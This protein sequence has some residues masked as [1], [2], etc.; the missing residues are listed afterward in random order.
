MGRS[1]LQGNSPTYLSPPLRQL[2]PPSS[3]HEDWDTETAMSTSRP[4]SLA[5]ARTASPGVKLPTLADILSNTAP[6]PWT[7]SAFTAYLSQNHCLETLEFIMEAERYRF[8]HLHQPATQQR[9]LHFEDETICSLWQRL[10]QAYIM[11]YGPREVNLP[12]PVRDRLLKLDYSL[13]AVPPPSELDEAVDIVRELMSDSLLVPFLESFTHAVFETRIEEEVHEERKSRSRLRIPKDLISSREEGSQSPKTNFLPLLGLGRSS[14]AANRSTLGCEPMELDLVTDDSSSP[15]STPGDEPMTPPTTPPTSD[16]T[17]ST[18]PNSLQRAIS[19]NSW[20]K[21]GAKLGLSRKN[22]SMRR[23]HPTKTSQSRPPTRK[24][25]QNFSRA[26]WEDPHPGQRLPIP[27]GS[28]AGTCGYPHNISDDSLGGVAAKTGDEHYDGRPVLVRRN[29]RA[30]HR[31]TMPKPLK[32]P[33]QVL[34]E[35]ECKSAPLVMPHRLEFMLP[36]SPARVP[37]LHMPESIRPLDLD[38]DTETEIGMSPDDVDMDEARLVETPPSL[39]DLSNFL[40][41]SFM[42][43]GYDD[44]SVTLVDSDNC[45]SV[46]LVEDLYGWEA[47]LDRKVQC[48]ISSADVYDCDEFDYP[49]A[50]D[51]KPSLLHRVFGTSDALPPGR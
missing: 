6:P 51:N 12:A 20:K 40:D 18:S 27:T 21:M 32:I 19:G 44:A 24:D 41:V 43:E 42:D 35:P 33:A 23:S 34:E 13:S 39:V 46:D 2:T 10:M 8:A 7:L 25:V 9:Q 15:N 22:R 28:L 1:R 45:R 30:R 36:S 48:G 16:Y 47:E 50:S 17:F 3:V 14:P 31:N 38:T 4:T 29:P 26:S 5:F 37:L 49:M 11:P